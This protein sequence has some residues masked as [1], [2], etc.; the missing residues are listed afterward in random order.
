MDHF[1]VYIFACKLHAES[2]SIG[3]MDGWME[4]SI[5][6]VLLLFRLDVLL[7]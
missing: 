2:T 3:W 6:F 4:E 5:G 7:Y 1:L